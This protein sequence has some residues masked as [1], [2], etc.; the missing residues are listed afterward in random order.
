MQLSDAQQL[1]EHKQRLAQAVILDSRIG[2]MGPLD[3]KLGNLQSHPLGQIEDFRIE[4]DAMEPLPRE[5]RFRGGL[6]EHFKSAL[7]VGVIDAQ[8]TVLDQ[9]VDFA[10]QHARQ[11]LVLFDNRS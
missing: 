3:W 4:N 2:H 11:A 5:Q 1:L 9:G 10:G 6:G 8:I 7:R